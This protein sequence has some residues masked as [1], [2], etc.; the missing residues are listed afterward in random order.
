MDTQII[1]TII[2]SVCLLVGTIVSVVVT[3]NKTRTELEIRQ[4]FQQKEIED[5]KNKLNEHNDYAKS[6]PKLESEIQIL[7]DMLKEIKQ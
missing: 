4:N 3:S 1:V 6:I 7:F 5:I 2:S